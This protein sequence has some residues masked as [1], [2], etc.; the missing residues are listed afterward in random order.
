[1]GK[2]SCDTVAIHNTYEYQLD[3]FFT[4]G[5]SKLKARK[6]GVSVLR[7]FI[8]YYI[9]GTRYIHDYLVRATPV[10]GLRYVPFLLHVVFL[11][12]IYTEVGRKS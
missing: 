1:M 2:C 5:H 6:Y 8:F 7:Y 11:G 12:V 4:C 10:A 9:H 3:L